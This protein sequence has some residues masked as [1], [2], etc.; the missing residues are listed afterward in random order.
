MAR[1]HRVKATNGLRRTNADK[2]QCIEIAL[3]ESP[4]LSDRVITDMCGV[5]GACRPPEDCGNSAMPTHTTKDGTQYPAHRIKPDPAP[6]GEK[7]DYGSVAEGA[8]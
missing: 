5:K 1:R 2:L 3:W 8:S 7:G 4:Q 6:E